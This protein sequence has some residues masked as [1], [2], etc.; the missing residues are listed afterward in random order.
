MRFMK[1]IYSVPCNLSINLVTCFKRS[2]YTFEYKHV[3]HGSYQSSNKTKNNRT[4]F[5]NS[6]D[7]ND[8]EIRENHLYLYG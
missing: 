4:Q 7:L 5:K 8:H 1:N 3:D 2:R 6:F